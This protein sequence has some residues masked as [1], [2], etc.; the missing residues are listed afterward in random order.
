[1]SVTTT[2]S[3]ESTLSACPRSDSVPITGTAVSSTWN[4][5]S[6][7]ATRSGTHTP[8]TRKP[9]PA[10]SENR[11]VMVLALRTPPM[12]STLARKSP[13]RRLRSTQV[14]QTRRSRNRK[15]SPRMNAMAMKPRDGCHLN[16]SAMMASQAK[17][18][19][20]ARATDW[21]WLVPESSTF[22]SRV[23]K[24]TSAIIQPMKIVTLIWRKLGP[25]RRSA[26]GGTGST[27]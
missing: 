11:K 17:S 25:R 20:V 26:S 14:R 18:V 19:N 12:T 9:D 24:T 3:T 5:S 23:R 27:R 16:S 2:V 8:T 7:A 6:A 15:L 22:G 21:Y 13:L 1:M 4:R 10:S